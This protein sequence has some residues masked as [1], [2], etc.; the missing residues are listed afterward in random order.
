MSDRAQTACPNPVYRSVPYLHV[1]DVEA[2]LDFYAALGFE[3]DTILRDERGRAFWASAVSESD[4]RP[5]RAEVFFARADAPVIPE[6]QAVL[7][8]MYT[9]DVARMR[10]HLLAA[11]LHDG[12]AYHGQQG[13]NRGRRVVFEAQHPDYMKRGELRIADPD[14]YCILMGQLD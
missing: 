14:G 1:A 7:F 11:G 9:E 3:P 6:Q 10:A 4:G 13:P 12:G 2:S 8:Y 5:S